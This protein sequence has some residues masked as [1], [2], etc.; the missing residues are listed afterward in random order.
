MLLALA[1]AGSMLEQEHSMSAHEQ[2][3]CFTALLADKKWIA[4]D[5]TKRNFTEGQQ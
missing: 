5:K 3:Q 1:G 4:I 2:I